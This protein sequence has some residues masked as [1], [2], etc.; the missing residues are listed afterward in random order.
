MLKVH[1]FTAAALLACSLNG[2][3]S[4]QEGVVNSEGQNSTA[5]VATARVNN[6]SLEAQIAEGQAIVA[7]GD[8]LSTRVS[9]MLDAARKE[10]DIIRITCLNEKLTQTNANLRNAQKRLE[11]LS[12]AVDS[13][14]RNHEFTVL[15]VIGQ[16]LQTLDQ[17]SNQCIG[18][19]I[20]ETGATRVETDIDTAIVPNEDPTKVFEIP[21]AAPTITT[22]ESS[23]T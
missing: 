11:A 22:I 4:A 20:F 10:A 16:K 3:V 7:R 23:P 6:M 5:G 8:R 18:Q 2:V 15:T 13:D 12:A 14:R 17:E 21:P 9:G 19:D 1:F